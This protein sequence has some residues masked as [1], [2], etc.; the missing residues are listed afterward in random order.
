MLKRARKERGQLR[1]AWQ[2][3]AGCPRNKSGICAG[4]R[5][6]N[7]RCAR[8]DR[9]LDGLPAD[10]LWRKNMVRRDD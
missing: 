9:A 1:E 3:V 6:A 7:C 10:S 4:P 2:A 5:D 8:G